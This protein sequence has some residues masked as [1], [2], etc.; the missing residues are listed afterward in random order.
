MLNEK[1]NELLRGI[2]LCTDPPEH[3]QLRAVLRRPLERHELKALEPEI[4]AEAQH[5][6]DRLVQQRTFDAAADLARHLPL[7]IVSKRVGLPE[8]GRERMLD[9]AFAN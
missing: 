5:L 7:E 4:E 2:V 6:V 8:E 3:T 1:M 9:W